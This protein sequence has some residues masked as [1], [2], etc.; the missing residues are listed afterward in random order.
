MSTTR[1]ACPKAPATERPA[2]RAALV[3]CAHGTRGGLVEA[4]LHAARLARLGRFAEVRVASLTGEPTL[5]AVVAGLSADEVYVVPLLMAE[6]Y[7]AAEVLPR[8]LAELPQN[9]RP[10]TLCRPIGSHPRMADLLE[11]AA[12]ATCR[13]RGWQPGETAL[14]VLGHGTPRNAASTGTA[15][16][17]AARLARRGRFA[18]V[19]TA[20]LEQAPGLAEVLESCA[21][22]R[23]TVVVGL[24]A[25]RGLHPDLDVPRIL[26]AFGARAA[27][28]GPVGALPEIGELILDRV[29]AACVEAA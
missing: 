24:F 6:G 7:T 17:H 1:S 4:P 22:C 2:R 27:Y 19:E 13:G 11:K 28:A 15:L 12:T 29:G 20:F 26:E 8:A 23:G 10:V 18:R 3:L 21:S 14:V 25:D 16:D 9:G 5:G